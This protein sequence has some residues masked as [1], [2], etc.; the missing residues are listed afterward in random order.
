MS[1]VNHTA[2]SPALRHAVKHSGAAH[3]TVTLHSTNPVPALLP[4]LHHHRTL[5]NAHTLVDI[6]FSSIETI[7]V[8]EIFNIIESIM[9][10]SQTLIKSNSNP[11]S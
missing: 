8:I 4:S 2:L 7:D 1:S 6:I 5:T 10:L 11:N 3:L 9:S